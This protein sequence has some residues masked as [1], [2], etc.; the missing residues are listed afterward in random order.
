[1]KC[2]VYTQKVSS[3]IN[4]GLKFLYKGKHCVHKCMS[5]TCIYENKISL[6]IKEFHFLTWNFLKLRW[7]NQSMP[8]CAQNGIKHF[9]FYIWFTS[10]YVCYMSGYVGNVLWMNRDFGR[11]FGLPYDQLDIQFFSFSLFYPF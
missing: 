10:L 2:N 9:I 8:Q 6:K 5:K 3:Y 7:L 1:M 4:E 11:K